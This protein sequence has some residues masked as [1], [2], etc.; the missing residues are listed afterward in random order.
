M[1]PGAV[2]VAAAALQNKFPLFGKFSRN[3]GNM[4]EKY[5]HVSSTSGK[6]GNYISGFLVKRSEGVV[7]VR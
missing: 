7:G 1:I 2:F 4:P 3:P 6:Y 5:R